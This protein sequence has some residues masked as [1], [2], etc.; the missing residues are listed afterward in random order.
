MCACELE[1]RRERDKEDGEAERQKKKPEL[2][3]ASISIVWLHLLKSTYLSLI[4]LA[5]AC[6][7]FISFC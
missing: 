4:I 6:V 2:L 1:R 5:V 3:A 7:S